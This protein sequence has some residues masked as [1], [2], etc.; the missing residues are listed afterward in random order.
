MKAIDATP[1]PTESTE[2]QRLFLWARMESGRYPCLKKMYH[3]PNEGKRTRATGGRLRAE[4]LKKG[5]PDICLPVA[6]G[7]SHGLYIEMKRLK[8]SNPT[9]EQEEWMDGLYQE[10][11]CVAWCRGWESASMI[12]LEYLKSGK[13]TYKPA[14]GRAGEFCAG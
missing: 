7:S 6:R 1:I 12:I 13:V 14:R 8:D 5:M 4:G 2:Q 10:G 9:P 11:Y 3:I